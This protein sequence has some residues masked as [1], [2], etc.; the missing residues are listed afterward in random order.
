M[1]AFLGMHPP[2]IYVHFL[3]LF[4]RITQNS[5]YWQVP[6]STKFISGV[7]ENSLNTHNAMTPNHHKTAGA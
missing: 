6:V 5:T 3:P 2:G 7:F 4:L 1:P